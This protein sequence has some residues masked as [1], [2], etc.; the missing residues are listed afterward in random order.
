[1]PVSGN[2]IAKLNQKVSS[3]DIIAEATWSR[4]HLLIDV[5]R[6]L[7]ISA[8]AA[9]RLIRVKVNEKVAEGAEIAIG[10]GMMARTIRARVLAAWLRLAAG[11]S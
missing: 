4:E 7:S 5:A 2:V 8:N 3:T 10:K 6:G 1:L 11:R 9:D